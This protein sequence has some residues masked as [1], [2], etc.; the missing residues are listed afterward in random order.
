MVG[1]EVLLL[2]VKVIAHLRVIFA[3]KFLLRCRRCSGSA[4]ARRGIRMLVFT[5][6]I[7]DPP[8]ISMSKIQGGPGESCSVAHCESDKIL[9]RLSACC[10]RGR[11]LPFQSDIISLSETHRA[12]AITRS[13][14]RPNGLLQDP[15][16]MREARPALSSAGP[17]MCLGSTLWNRSM[18]IVTGMSSLTNMSC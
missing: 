6:F 14:R 1:C 17:K 4:S 18:T 2:L 8:C 12:S 5:V 16:L 15:Q 11:S 10:A 3:L 7:G 9:L 13:N